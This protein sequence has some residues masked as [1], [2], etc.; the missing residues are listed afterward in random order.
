MRD[1]FFFFQAEDG[2][3]DLVRSRGLGDVY[4]RQK[5]G[6]STAGPIVKLPNGKLRGLRH[7]VS[8]FAKLKPQPQKP[9]KPEYK[10]RAPKEYK[11]QSVIDALLAVENDDQ[12]LGAMIKNLMAAPKHDIVKIEF[13]PRIWAKKKIQS[14]ISGAIYGA[15]ETAYRK[16]RGPGVYVGD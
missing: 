12:A 16:R 2:I 15:A 3:R 10:P 8:Q 13:D 14:W 4:K 11:D 7:A 1:G 9:S 5:V 6:S